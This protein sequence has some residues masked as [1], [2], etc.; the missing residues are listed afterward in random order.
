MRE[1]PVRPDGAANYP[2]CTVEPNVGIVPV[3][4]PRLGQ[5]AAVV[6]P[7][8]IVPAA[9]EFVDIA[10]LVKGASQGEG[11]GNQFLGHI[12]EVDAIA[13]VVRCFEDP[14]VVHVEHSVDPVR[15]HDIITAELALADLATVEKRLDKQRKAARSGDKDAAAGVALLERTAEHLGRG[16]GARDAITSDEDAKLLRQL[17]LLTA[18]PILYAANVDEATLT[19]GTSPLT[20]ALAEAAAAHHEEAE[21]VMFSAKLEAELAELDEAHRAEFLREAG[22][23]E[24]GLDRLIH[25]GYHLLGLATFFTAGETEVRA[26]TFHRGAKAPEC[27]GIIH[28][29]FER[30]FIRAETIG[31]E[32]LVRV[33]GEKNARAQGLMRSEGKEYVVQDGDVM[34]FRFNV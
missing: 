10:G 5:I 3:P 17:G 8:K 34:L 33:G 19:R 7:G 27:A 26:W 16:E 32:D 30:G 20:D 6:K 15:D 9:V 29:D 11:L 24:S 23:T 12:R 18:K 22:I 2:F 28:S 14:D 25:A 4:D 1:H 31:W 13:H 21:V